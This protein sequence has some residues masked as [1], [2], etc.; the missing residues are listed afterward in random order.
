MQSDLGTDQERKFFTALNAS[1]TELAGVTAGTHF[2]MAYGCV[3]YYD[4]FT[5]EPRHTY[6]SQAW[7]A[8]RHFFY[9]VGDMND[10]A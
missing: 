7:D 4:M 8:T 6:F 9:P 2:L 3:R 10:I 5:E 1:N